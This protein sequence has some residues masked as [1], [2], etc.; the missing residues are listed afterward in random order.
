MAI[1][2]YNYIDLQRI[3]HGSMYQ[4]KTC[5]YFILSHKSLKKT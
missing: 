4:Q 1:D 5:I 3:S 2:V